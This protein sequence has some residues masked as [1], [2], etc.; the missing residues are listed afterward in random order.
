M[1]SLRELRRR[2]LEAEI[3]NVLSYVV[4]SVGVCGMLAIWM[5]DF[6]GLF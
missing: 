3:R 4:L 5:L 6:Y 2:E 1:N